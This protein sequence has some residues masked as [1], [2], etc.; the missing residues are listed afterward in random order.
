MSLYFE[1]IWWFAS[2]DVNAEP[3]FRATFG[4]RVYLF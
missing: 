4:L 1:P 2:S 3:I